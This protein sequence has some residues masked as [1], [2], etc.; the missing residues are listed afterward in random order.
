[1]AGI[2]IVSVTPDALTTPHLADTS[3]WIWVRDRRFPQLAEWFSRAVRD[4][5][6]VTCTTV[7]M[8]LVRGAP[9]PRAATATARTL[10]LL[11]SVPQDEA[12]MERA[13]TVQLELAR[14]GDHR[15]VPVPDLQIAAAAELAGVPVLHYD[16]DFERIAQ[17]SALRERRLV[18]AGTLA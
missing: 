10:A 8:E 5:S 14:T 2:R 18:P 16:E 7:G 1:M 17:V 4:G 12:A 15:R 3:V 9:S 6:I 11:G 13:A